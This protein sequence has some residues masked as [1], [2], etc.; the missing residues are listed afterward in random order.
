MIIYANDCAETVVQHTLHNAYTMTGIAGRVMA[1][2]DT[3]LA[4]DLAELSDCRLAI[5]F[6]EAIQ[7]RMMIC[8]ALVLNY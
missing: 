4:T 2:F 8:S 5:S 3:V 6:E 7:L 1:P